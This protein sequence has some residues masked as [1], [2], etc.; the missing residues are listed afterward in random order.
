MAE[1]RIRIS[2][3]GTCMVYVGSRAF[4]DR[5]I[6]PLMEALGHLDAEG[7][8]ETEL[9]APAAPEGPV[10]TPASPPHFAQFAAQVG[11]RATGVEQRIMAFAF[12][13][14]NFE[15][16]EDCR[17]VQ[18]AAFFRTLQEDPPADLRVRLGTLCE[19]KRFLEVV[20]AHTWRL[21]TKGVNYVKN[22]LL[23]APPA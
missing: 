8:A 19:T 17:E 6:A 11:P 18:I 9:Q 14:W 21:S 22:R 12:Y 1:V 15:K 4:F 5:S 20:D 3:G 2:I 10:W 13:L 23:A 16:Q 7:E